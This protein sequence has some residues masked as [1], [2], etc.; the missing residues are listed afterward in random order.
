[1]ST[2]HSPDDAKY[3][4]DW[5][6]ED[7]KSYF[8]LRF[9]ANNEGMMLA[10]EKGGSAIG[11]YFEYIAKPEAVALVAF[12]DDGGP[13]ENLAEP[14]SFQYR[15]ATNRLEAAPG[16]LLSRRDWPWPGQ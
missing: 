13:R 14:V 4:G 3:L 10:M 7:D 8:G 5:L 11:R 6:F 2:Q 1:M 15:H 16:A 12:W 9:M